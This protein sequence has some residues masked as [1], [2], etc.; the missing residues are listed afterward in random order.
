MMVGEVAEKLVC[1]CTYIYYNWYMYAFAVLSRID[2]M[3][4]PCEYAQVFILFD[5]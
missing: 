2:S 3:A 4:I 1:I 5:F